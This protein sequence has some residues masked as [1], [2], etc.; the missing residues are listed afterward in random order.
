MPIW[1]GESNFIVT[2]FITDNRVGKKSEI[3]FLVLPQTIGQ[4]KLADSQP[5]GSYTPSKAR[6]LI[7]LDDARSAKL[8][9]SPGISVLPFDSPE[10]TRA[11]RDLNNNPVLF[12]VHPQHY[13]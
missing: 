11:F 2:N 8:E 6:Q 1:S 7:P 3:E 5:P 10:V 13:L 12:L 9:L 4:Y